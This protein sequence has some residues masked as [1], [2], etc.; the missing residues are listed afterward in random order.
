M[1]DEEYKEWYEAIDRRIEQTT[2]DYKGP[3]CCLTMEKALEVRP[4]T[5][6]YDDKCK[7]YYVVHPIPGVCLELFHC[8]FCGKNLLWKL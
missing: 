7:T 3:H 4:D 8:M 1:N 2:Q 6:S 5:F